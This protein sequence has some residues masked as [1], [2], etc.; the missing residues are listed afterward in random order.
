MKDLVQDFFFFHSRGFASVNFQSCQGIYLVDEVC[1][2]EI[3]LLVVLA[4]LCHFTEEQCHAQTRR[5]T[6]L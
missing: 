3:G 2:N 4:K 6:G 5:G 1:W